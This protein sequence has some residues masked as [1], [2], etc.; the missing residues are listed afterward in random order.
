MLQCLFILPTLWNEHPPRERKESIQLFA[1]TELHDPRRAQALSQLAHLILHKKPTEALDMLHAALA[2][3]LPERLQAELDL[4]ECYLILQKLHEAALKAEEILRHHPLSS[5][6]MVLRAQ[7]LLALRLL[8]QAEAIISALDNDGLKFHLHAAKCLQELEEPTPTEEATIKKAHLI[9][10]CIQETLSHTRMTIQPD[11]LATWHK[12]LNRYNH[13]CKTP[14][15]FSQEKSTTEEVSAYR[16][17]LASK[18]TEISLDE[19]SSAQ[20]LIQNVPQRLELD[21]LKSQ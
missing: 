17:E 19:L 4:A 7:A 18:L 21:P 13:W 15:I 5:Q 3:P 14:P 12:L 6:A 10:T 11:A 8:P 2:G 9:G 1:K 20:K 16:L